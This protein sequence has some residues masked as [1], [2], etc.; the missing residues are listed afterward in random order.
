MGAQW[1]TWTARVAAGGTLTNE[2]LQLVAA[3]PEILALGMLADTARRAQR[4]RVVTYLRVASV[5]PDQGIDAAAVAAAGEVRVTGA[6]PGREAAEAQL[7]RVRREAGGRMV[8]A[9]SLADIEA[10]GEGALPGVLAR[11]RAAGLDGVA[12]VPVD[13]LKSPGA[14]V[15]ALVEAGFLAIRVT[16]EKAGGE[17]RLPLL[18]ALQAAAAA[19][20]VTAVHPLPLVLN[21]FRPTTGY[22]DVRAIALA[23]L[24][25]PASVAVQVDW[26]RYGPKLAQVALTFGADDIYG[27]PAVDAAPDGPR[28]GL[29]L[30]VRR[31]IEAAGFEAVERDASF[32]R[33][34]SQA[35]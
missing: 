30:E 10:A 34:A 8:T 11:L 6:Y 4:G 26:P 18:E 2:E 24:A 21:P 13:R 27:V 31:N 3:S 1:E 22:E 32:A 35:V 19:G 23:R 25:M 16:V 12:E 9:W 28:R 17:S 15:E 20:P 29:L 7:A 5:D 14:A 33:S